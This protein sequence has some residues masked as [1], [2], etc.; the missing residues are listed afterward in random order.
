M[1]GVISVPG[2][3]IT[4]AFNVL[5]AFEA[6]VNLI[7][8][9][10]VFR[11][12]EGD[13]LGHTKDRLGGSGQNYHLICYI[14][15][16]RTGKSEIS[17]DKAGVDADPVVAVYDTQET[18]AVT[19]GDPV[20]RDTVIEMPLTFADAVQNIK[21]RQFRIMPAHR[22]QMYGTGTNYTLVVQRRKL[23]NRFSVTVSGTV[24]K[25]NGIPVELVSP[26]KICVREF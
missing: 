10:I 3:I 26:I 11:T 20:V 23:V 7:I 15:D 14:P 13:A 18:V 19:W 2:D 1:I 17:I 6:N 4:G 16:V 12:L 5:F 24:E 8:D 25:T 22:F 9:D 21:K